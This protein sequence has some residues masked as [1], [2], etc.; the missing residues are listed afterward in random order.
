[1]ES[2]AAIAVDNRQ[3]AAQIAEQAADLMIRRAEA[4]RSS[5]PQEF[6]RDLRDFGWSL[7]HAQ[8]GDGAAGQPGQSGSV[9]D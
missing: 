5:S 4:S 7:I 6:R 1:V 8:T 2:V 9:G 3:G